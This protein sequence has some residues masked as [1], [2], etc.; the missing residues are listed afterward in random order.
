[1]GIVQGVVYLS[2]EFF[3]ERSHLNF[4]SDFRTAIRCNHVVNAGIHPWTFDWL[5]A[6]ALKEF[7]VFII[8]GPCL[9]FLEKRKPVF[10]ENCTKFA[11]YWNDLL[12][13]KMKN[14]KTSKIID[15]RK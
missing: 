12:R 9:W 10:F 2:P 3:S 4:T 6:S 1:M 13:V 14:A 11:I 7:S 15:L 5:N 8:P